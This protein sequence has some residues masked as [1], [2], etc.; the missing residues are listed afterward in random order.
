[1][2]EIIVKNPKHL[3]LLAKRKNQ[4]FVAII[5]KGK[6]KEIIITPEHLEIRGGTI[7]DVRGG[8]IQ[9]VRGG[10]IQDVWGNAVLIIPQNSSAVYPKDYPNI[11]TPRQINRTKDGWLKIHTPDKDGFVVLY[12]SVKDDYTDFKTGKIKYVIGKEVIAPD[13]KD[14]INIECGNGL[15]LCPI[16]EHTQDFNKGKILRCL[17]S[18]DDILIHPSPKYP[19]KVRCRKV[20]VESK[21][22]CA[23]GKQ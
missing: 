8:T 1:M 17:V 9:N 23:G 14:D 18:P 11:L 21:A 3:L 13:W 2:K 19:T 10:T 22:D 7:Q 5:D 16:P 4:D 20:F 6:W 15:H 12:K